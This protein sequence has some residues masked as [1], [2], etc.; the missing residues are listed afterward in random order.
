MYRHGARYPSGTAPPQAFQAKLYN[1]TQTVKNLGFTGELDFLNSWEYRLG[2]E[3]LTPFGR[4]QNFELGVAFRQQY[5]ALL[6][7]FTRQNALPVFTTESQDR[8]VKTALNFMGGFFGI[9]EYST[10]ANL[11]LRIEAQGFNNTGAPYYTCPNSNVASRGQQGSGAASKFANNAFN[12]TLSRLNSQAHG[13]TF[14]P[15]DAVAMLQLCS[16]ET[17]A[18]GYSKFCGLFTEEDFRNYEYYYD[19]SF[20]YNNGPGSPVSAAQGKGYAQEILARLQQ[21]YITES[22]SSINYTLTDNPTDFPL[23]QSIYADATH[24]VVVLDTLTALNLTALFKGGALNLNQR[25]D[26]S[27]AFKSSQTVP[28]ATHLVIQIMECSNMTPTKQARFIV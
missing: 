9:P 21:H 3:L 8:M 12:S 18:L 7:N 15:S 22:H 20:Y 5:G 1:A 4:S 24:E 25:V 17:D 6:N 16:Y 11:L 2:A 28:F 13:I 27:S 23:N 26:G 10:E 14:T 19:L